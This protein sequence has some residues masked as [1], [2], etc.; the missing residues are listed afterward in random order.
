MNQ[1]VIRIDDGDW[2]LVG[3]GN[4]VSKPLMDCI[5]RALDGDD[6]DHD[7]DDA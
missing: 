2:S 3:R 5:E 6:H 1:A 7:D 4:S